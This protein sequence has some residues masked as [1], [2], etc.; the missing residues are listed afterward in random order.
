M[1]RR[2]AVLGHPI[3]HSKS[4]ALHSAAYATLGVDIEYSA[5]DV[6]VERLPGF[7][8]SLRGDDT[9]CGLSVTMPLK[10]A[11]ISQVDEV[12]GAG[13]HLGVINTVV[14]ERDGAQVRRVGYNTD[15]A[16]IV[17]AVRYAGVVA[18]PH[19]AILGGGGTS[20]AAVAAVKELGARHVDVFVRDAGRAGDAQAA[21]A[22]VG[23]SLAVRPLTEAASAVAGM[24]LVISTFPPRAADPLAE[25]LAALPRTG[26]GVLLDVAYDPWPSRLAEVWQGHGGAVVPGLEMLMYQAAEQIRRFSGCDVDAAVIDVMCDSVGLPRRVF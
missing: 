24:N 18:A 12:R 4:P 14:F 22:A 17:E 11:M 2:A 23:L 15:V 10:S 21:A 16:G 5:I 13:A 9:W 6:T 3:S 26:G 8:E 7:M 20:A 19:A 25:E 1:S